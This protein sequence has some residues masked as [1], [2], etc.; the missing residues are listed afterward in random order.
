MVKNTIGEK[1]IYTTLKD[2]LDI[3]Y[4]KKGL[5]NQEIFREVVNAISKE[6]FGEPV[7]IKKPTAKKS[8]EEKEDENKPVK[9]RATKKTI[10]RKEYKWT[11]LEDG[12]EYCQEIKFSDECYAFRDSSTKEIVGAIGD[13]GTRDLTFND[14]T[15][16]AK[17]NF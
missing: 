10:T 11:E 9:T 13:D 3:S 14:K 2:L 7:P 6:E 4:E 17:L 12:Y 16:L 1:I 15:M 5:D 8:T